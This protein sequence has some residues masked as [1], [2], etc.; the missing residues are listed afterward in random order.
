MRRKAEVGHVQNICTRQQICRF[1]SE[2]AQWQSKSLT[3][4][5]EMAVGRS[6]Y[7]VFIWVPSGVTENCVLLASS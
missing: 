2:D 3:D 1:C 7:W 4:N 6:D 5:Q